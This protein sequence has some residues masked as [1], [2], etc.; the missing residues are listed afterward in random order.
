MIHHKEMNELCFFQSNKE[1]C[2]FRSISTVDE[3]DENSCAVDEDSQETQGEDLVVVE[4]QIFDMN[5]TPDRVTVEQFTQI[6][7]DGKSLFCMKSIVLVLSLCCFHRF[8]DIVPS[9]MVS[10]ENSDAPVGEDSDVPASKENVSTPKMT[11]SSK[12]SKP[13]QLAIL[14]P[15]KEKTGNHE[16]KSKAKR[17]A[18]LSEGINKIVSSLESQLTQKAAQGDEQEILLGQEIG[19]SLLQIPNKIVRNKWKRKFREML[20]D[21]EDEVAELEEGNM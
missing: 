17:E 12:K 21:L 13:M 20:C 1:M 3:S 14:S 10:A 7:K 16:K 15:K 8:I 2:S 11:V 19:K 18:E 4:G 9:C 5:K 6:I